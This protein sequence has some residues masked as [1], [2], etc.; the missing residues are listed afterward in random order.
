MTFFMKISLFIFERLQIGFFGKKNGYNIGFFGLFL[1]QS[2]TWTT[3]KNMEK[4]V[5]TE[6][7][8]GG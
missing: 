1:S 7:K 8:I 2:Q 4:L 6:F 3:L 5:G